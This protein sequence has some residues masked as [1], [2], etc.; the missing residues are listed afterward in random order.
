MFLELPWLYLAHLRVTGQ[1]LDLWLAECRPRGWDN[2]AKAAPHTNT[3]MEDSKP[4]IFVEGSHLE[5]GRMTLAW[6]KKRENALAFS[7]KP[8]EVK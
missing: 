2:L 4:R 8:A 6:K 7:L 5:T 1:V 3:G